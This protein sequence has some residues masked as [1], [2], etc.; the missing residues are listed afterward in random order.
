MWPSSP[1]NLVLFHIARSEQNTFSCNHC[2]IFV[3]SDHERLITFG[4]ISSSRD[5]H[6]SRLTSEA[7]RV[8]GV[9]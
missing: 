7:W 3:L 2:A 1:R 9:D 6:W 8:R 5:K 4:S